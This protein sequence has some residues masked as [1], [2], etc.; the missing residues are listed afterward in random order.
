MLVV[1]RARMQPARLMRAPAA[2]M[3]LRPCLSER[4]PTTRR[5]AKAVRAKQQMMIPVTVEGSPAFST[6]IATPLC[7]PFA[8]ID[9]QKVTTIMTSG[10]ALAPVLQAI[11]AVL[12]F[13]LAIVLAVKGVKT[14]VATAKK[15][16]AAKAE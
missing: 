10:I 1:N 14:I 16:K 2:M 7:T 6:R 12:L 3:I 4:L 9:P 11:L 15:Q 5:D 8:V 13:V